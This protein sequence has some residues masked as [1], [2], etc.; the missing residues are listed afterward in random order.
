MPNEAAFYDD[1]RETAEKQFWNREPCMKN[2]RAA[3]KVVGRA[4]SVDVTP[5]SRAGPKVD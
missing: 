2:C 4:I 1:D 5:D 3:P